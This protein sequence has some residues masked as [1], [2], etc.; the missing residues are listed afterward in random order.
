MKM[1]RISY[2]NFALLL[3]FLFSLRLSAPG[4]KSVRLRRDFGSSLLK[5]IRY[6]NILL[7]KIK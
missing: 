6:W 2:L 7:T 5:R 1:V 3:A 4:E